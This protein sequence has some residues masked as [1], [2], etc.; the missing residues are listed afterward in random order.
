MM[1]ERWWAPVRLLCV[2]NTHNN[3][4]GTIW[5]LSQLNDVA[6]AAAELGIPRHLD[7]A[8][9]WHATAATGIAEAD[10]AAGF[11]TVSVCFSKALGAPMGS[12]LAGSSELIARAR[13]FKQQFGGGF[14]QAGMMAAGALHA[15]RHHRARLGE[16]HTLAT[17]F[18][19]G[20][21]DPRGI[22]IDPSTVESNIVRFTLDGVSSTAFVDAAHERG[23]HLL[24]SGSDGVRT[25]FYLDITRAD[26]DHAVAIIPETLPAA[27]SAAAAAGQ[28]Q[29][30]AGY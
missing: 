15:L 19:H 5:P 28:H 25:V 16:T 1:S 11:D 7:G 9:L 24:P 14:R 8:R 21:A 3:G 30:V 4:G 29:T 22:A 27:A 17:T 23:V 26:V 20:I 2:E 18:A 13:R 10:Y 12:C 6:D